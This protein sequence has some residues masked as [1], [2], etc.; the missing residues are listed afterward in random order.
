MVSGSK[1]QPE[2][3]RDGFWRT[4]IAGDSGLEWAFTC[5]SPVRAILSPASVGTASPDLKLLASRRSRVWGRGS[6]CRSPH[7]GQRWAGQVQ[8]IVSSLALAFL[9]A[10]AAVEALISAPFSAW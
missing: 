8:R 2:V 1:I 3:V 5:L 10:V 6:V 4:I 9:A 7:E